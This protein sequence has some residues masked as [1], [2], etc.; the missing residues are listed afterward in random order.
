MRQVIRYGMLLFKLKG[1]EPVMPVLQKIK[2]LEISTPVERLTRFNGLIFELTMRMDNGLEIG[3]EDVI[4]EIESELEILGNDLGEVTKL[5]TYFYVSSYFVLAGKHSQALVWL[6]H[7]LN[8]PRTNTRT[9]MQCAARILHLLIHY[10]LGHFDLLEYSLKSASRFI[11]K[12]ERMYE[13]ERTFLKHIR[14]LSNAISEAERN[15][16]LLEM[17]TAIEEVVEDPFERRALNFFNILYW[18]EGKLSNRTGLQVTATKFVTTEHRENV[19][20]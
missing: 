1:M 5:D 11:Y 7:F 8:H 15:T 6:N 9:D 13:Y 17:K 4:A 2:A 20:K 14:I 19:P 12:Q 3:T 16:K 18:I 10:E